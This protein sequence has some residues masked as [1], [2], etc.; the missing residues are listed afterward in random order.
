MR[1]TVTLMG[2]YN[3]D[4]TI[5]D[6]FVLP[7][8][9]SADDQNNFKMKL[10]MDTAELELLYS[11]PEFLR[12]AIG[13]WSRSYIANWEKLYATEHFNYNPIWNKDSKITESENIGRTNKYNDKR[14]GSGTDEQHSTE[15]VS[16]EDTNN[17]TQTTTN[18]QTNDLDQVNTSTTD[19]TSSTNKD[20]TGSSETDTTSS[21]TT[22]DYVFGFNE[23]TAAQSEQH[24]TETT[25]KETG[26]TTG[27]ETGSGTEKVTVNADQINTGTVKDEGTVTNTGNG[28]NKSNTD[29]WTTGKSASTETLDHTGSDDEDRQYTRIEQGNIGVTTTQS[30]I[31]QER[32]VVKFNLQDY[33]IDSFKQKFCLLI[34]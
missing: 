26:S 12:A 29:G 34:Y 7:A 32:T 1:S 15:S 33:I 19:T 16:G 5:L 8:E 13:F 11:N 30:M 3:A 18:T 17:A 10:I 4:N 14:D 27:K 22:K 9:W 2:L 25:G 31:Q 21:S 23:S 28:T 24:E 6:D 20:T